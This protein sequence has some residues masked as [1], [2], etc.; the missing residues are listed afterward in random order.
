MPTQAK[1]ILIITGTRPNFIK[2][3]QFKK[4]AQ[5]Y[6]HYQV[7]IVHTGQHF[8]KSMAEIF[9]A[10]FNMQPDYFLNIKPGSA[11]EQMAEIILSLHKHV[12][13]HGKPDLMLVPGDVNS[14]QA[15]ALVA[16]KLGIPLGH[17]ESGLR[18]FDRAMPEEINRI[19][20]DELTDLFFVTEPSGIENL[21]KENRTGKICYVGNTMIDT[22]V[23][24]N[25]QIEQST[26]LNELDVQ[27]QAYFLVTLHRPS[28]VD[29]EQGLRK[30]LQLL[31]KL[32]ERNKVV[33][34]VH[35][36]TTKNIAA[37]GLE[38]EFKALKNVIFTEPQGYFQFQK[39][40]ANAKAVITDS[41]GIQEETTFRQIPCLT[42]RENTERPVTLT[43]GTNTLTG[44]QADVIFPLIN[45][46]EQGTYKKGSIPKHWDG[47]ATERIFQCIESF[48]EQ[49]N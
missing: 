27:P 14:T 3:T 12:T 18:S 30:V 7:E 22:L 5:Q 6:P 17:I 44:L 2:V 28:N 13:E 19:V 20:T 24:F 16:S 42:L 37:L 46:I 33:F 9:F 34:P 47:K 11:I 35:P 43:H 39:L 36:R 4:V 15:A 25:T 10:Q 49:E 40:I 48:F 29:V 23:A 31:Q 38:S 45:Q 26:I 41:G 8:D 21:T 32:T 1:K